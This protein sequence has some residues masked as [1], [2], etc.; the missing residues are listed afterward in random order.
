MLKHLYIANKHKSNDDLENGIDRVGSGRI[1]VKH[2]AL[3]AC[4]ILS[5]H[6]H[7]K[8]LTMPKLNV[9]SITFILCRLL[10]A[11]SAESLIA[12]TTSQADK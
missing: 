10:S 9:S 2:A 6:R 7:L 1:T 5:I 4:R 8:Y 3:Y 12:C 11:G